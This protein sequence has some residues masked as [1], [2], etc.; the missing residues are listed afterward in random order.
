M[1]IAGMTDFGSRPFASVA[2]AGGY[3]YIEIMRELLRLFQDG[4]LEYDAVVTVITDQ[5]AKLRVDIVI[6]W[7]LHIWKKVVDNVQAST[8]ES[9]PALHLY[10]RKR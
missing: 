8:A 9:K 3:R 7:L 1:H 5:S 6:G 4:G 10:V 2:L